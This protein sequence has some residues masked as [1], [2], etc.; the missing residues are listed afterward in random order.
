MSEELKLRLPFLFLNPGFGYSLSSI[1][2]HTHMSPNFVLK[3][4]SFPHEISS[5]Y[6]VQEGE[7]G[8]VPWYA[9]GMLNDNL[10]FFYKAYAH[11]DFLTDGHMELWIS[12]DVS[13]LEQFA[14]DRQ[15]YDIYS[16]N[17]KTAILVSE[18][19]EN[20]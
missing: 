11:S 15:T 7:L 3:P 12:S 10:Y 18:P 5:Y 19:S 14:M 6:W 2:R 16:K 8:K 20:Q 9:L 13:D 4:D 17:N 1:L